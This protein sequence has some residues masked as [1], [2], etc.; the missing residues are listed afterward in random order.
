MKLLTLPWRTLGAVALAAGVAGCA[1]CQTSAAKGDGKEVWTPLFDGM[2]LTGWDGL[3]NHWRAENGAIVGWTSKSDPIQNNTFLVWTNGTVGNFELHAKY[4][5]TAANDV[6]F[7]NSGIQYRSK[8]VDAQK[9]IVGGYQADMEA[10][11]TYS[12]IL[13]E[14]RGRGILAERGQRTRIVTD[15]GQTKVVK[16][17]QI[18]PSAELQAN[19]HGGDW[20]DYVIIANGNHLM[21]F[22]NHRLTIDVVDEQPDKAAKDGIL[23]LQLHAGAPMTVE[24]K[25]IQLKRLP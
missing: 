24:F 20:N 25:D 6:G 23:A 11:P 8:L 21:H 9:F 4:R 12:G 2:S 16:V 14:E 19:I 15:N 10:G 5:I 22:I 7:A 13:Y 18:A 1:C 3:K 17:G